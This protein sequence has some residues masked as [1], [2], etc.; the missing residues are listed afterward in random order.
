VISDTAILDERV[1]RSITE[2]RFRATRSVVF[3]GVALLATALP[4]RR[5]STAD[6]IEVIRN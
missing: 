4:A 6:P 1:A 5:A 2:E 3:G